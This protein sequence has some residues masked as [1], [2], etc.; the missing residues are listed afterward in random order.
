M[1]PARRPADADRRAASGPFASRSRRRARP[2]GRRLGA[3]SGGPGGG[4]VE[5]PDVA[6]D[7][8]RFAVVDVETTGGSPASAALTEI[9]V[10][11]FGGGQAVQVTSWLVHP[12]MPIPPFIT[13]LTG[14]SDAMVAGAPPVGDVLPALLDSIEG[15]VLVGHNL[16]FDVGFLDVA[17]QAAGLPTLAQPMVDTLVLAR[18]LLGGQVPNCRL[19]TLA[20]ALALPHQP[21]HRATADVLATAD[22]L[23]HLL[24]LL[25]QAGVRRLPELFAA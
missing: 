15:H 2:A 22:L 19:G 8:V 5:V 7:D 9:A 10:G 1:E 13:E 14:I 24:G 16:P 18:R 4:T 21:S 25:A 6:L 11:T 12:G 20:A 3:L 17:L 23:E